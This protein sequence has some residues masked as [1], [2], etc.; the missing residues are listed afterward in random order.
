MVWC[1]Q[2]PDQDLK[3]RKSSCRYR[4]NLFE[5]TITMQYFRYW[6]MIKISTK[7][8][9]YLIALTKCITEII[10]S[11]VSALNLDFGL[12]YIELTKIL[13]TLI[14]SLFLF[15]EVKTD[16]IASTHLM[17]LSS[18]KILLFKMS[19][20]FFF[21]TISTFN[22]EINIEVFFDFAFYKQPLSCCIY[23]I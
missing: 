17:Y 5:P 23:L 9:V 20:C 14:F 4:T 1:V 7:Q 18:S 21:N 10:C 8:V 3:F 16:Q 19:I 22:S 13:L 11:L 15:I 12:R 6:Q 2:I